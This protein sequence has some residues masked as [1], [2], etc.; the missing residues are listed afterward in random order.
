MPELDKL[1]ERVQVVEETVVKH[2]RR[3]LDLHEATKLHAEALAENT[4]M[5]RE[6]IDIAQVTANNT[7]ELVELFKGAKQLR[8]F[9]MWIAI[10]IGGAVYFLEHIWDKIK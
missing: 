9:I 1:C 10:P 7:A 6:S 4:R 8:K 5:T 3:I 2:D